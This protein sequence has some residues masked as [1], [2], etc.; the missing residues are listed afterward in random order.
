V[1]YDAPICAL[2]DLLKV[3]PAPRAVNVK[4]SRFGLVSELLRTYEWCE[5]RG[6]TVY[7]GGQFELGPGRG[8][9]QLLASLFHPDAAN[10]VAPAVFNEAALPERPPTS[11][12]PAPA[13]AHGFRWVDAPTR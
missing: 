9:I 2:A 10:D 6:V 4:P 7:G 11:P 13:D 3:F 8:Q 5:S 12:L 1:T